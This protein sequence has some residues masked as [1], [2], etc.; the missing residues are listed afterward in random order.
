MTYVRY[1][2]L[3]WPE[4]QAMGVEDRALG[5]IPTGA[6][7]QHG[8]HLPVGTDMLIA[9][10]LGRRIGSA[11]RVPVV[12][13]PVVPVG[14]SDVHLEFPGTVSV[15]TQALG[16]VV[17][18]YVEAFARAGLSK[19]AVFTAHGGNLELMRQ[20]NGAVVEG[21]TVRAHERLDRY[22]DAMHDAA[23]N[24][25]LV[26]PGSDQHGGGVETSQ[27]LASHPHLVGSHA[28]VVGFSGTREGLRDTIAKLGVRSMTPNGVFGDARGARAEAGEQ[29][30][31][32]LVDE[33]VGWLKKEYPE[34]ELEGER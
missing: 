19:V 16:A 28:E 3:S 17:T 32:A 7:E 33:F 27:L 9:E 1:E 2:H 6:V 26:V 13:A 29:I 8:P 5:L 18:A 15:A 23:E 12:V 10:E 21:V 20:L 34:L 4:F 22:I 30:Y 25:E 14:M 24:S 11:L 31:Q